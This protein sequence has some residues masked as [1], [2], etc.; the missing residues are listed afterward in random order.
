[1]RF[2]IALCALLVAPVAARAQADCG[3]DIVTAVADGATIHLTHASAHYNCCSTIF[4][5]VE[6]APG[7]WTVT[8]TEGGMYCFCTCC[9]TLTA[10]IDDAPPGEQTVTLRFMDYDTGAEREV[11]V[12]VTV[13]DVGQGGGGGLASTWKSDCGGTTGVSDPPAPSWGALKRHYR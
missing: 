9:F 11:S 1:M 2:L 12:A 6:P 10:R 4:F 7:G 3:E 5:A 8:E 13:P